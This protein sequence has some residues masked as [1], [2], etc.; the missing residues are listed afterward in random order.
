MCLQSLVMIRSM[1]LLELYLQFWILKKQWLLLEDSL[2]VAPYFQR[3][4]ASVWA[5]V[6]LLLTSAGFAKILH[7]F[8]VL[9][10]FLDSQSPAFSSNSVPGP[11]KE[12][13]PITDCVATANSNASF[14]NRHPQVV[15]RSSQ[16]AHSK[17]KM[18]KIEHNNQ[19][20]YLELTTFQVDP[21]TRSQLA[22]SRN[23]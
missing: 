20:R 2:F 6:T 23:G 1:L 15:N 21:D 22:T 18:L 11:Q 4:S 19:G 14:S 5:T 13:H 16:I 12:A 17:E 10:Y 7:R 9:P 3:R 8:T